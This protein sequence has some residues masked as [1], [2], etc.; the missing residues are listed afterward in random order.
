VQYL[1]GEQLSYPAGKSPQLDAARKAVFIVIVIQSEP[2]TRDSIDAGCEE[3]ASSASNSWN[4][5]LSPL[6]ALL[7]TRDARADYSYDSLNAVSAMIEQF[8]QGA[9][10]PAANNTSTCDY[11]V[12]A[13]TLR[14]RNRTRTDIPLTWVLSSQARN[15]MDA[16]VDGMEQADVRGGAP[17]ASISPVGDT[18]DIDRM[19]G[20]YRRVLCVL[21]ATQ[22]SQGCAPATN[23]PAN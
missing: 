9:S 8:S 23:P 5:A 12:C 1:I 11:P 18:Q 22:G 3:D 10:S 19:L 14:F 4:E 13:V 21:A 16:A 2:C 17:S 7:S 20:S 6:R 15:S